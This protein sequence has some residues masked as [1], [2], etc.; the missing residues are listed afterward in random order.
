[1][2]KDRVDLAEAKVNLKQAVAAYKRAEKEAR[3]E[4]K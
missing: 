1:M 3:E 2:A 4:A